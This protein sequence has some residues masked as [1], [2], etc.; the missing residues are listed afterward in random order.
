MVSVLFLPPVMSIILFVAVMYCLTNRAQL[1]VKTRER[2]EKYLKET[3]PYALQEYLQLEEDERFLV[4]HFL[5]T[6]RQRWN[7][8]GIYLTVRD[9]QGLLCELRSWSTDFQRMLFVMIVSDLALTLLPLAEQNETSL[10]GLSQQLIIN[11]AFLLWAISF[12]CIFYL[13]LKFVRL[14]SASNV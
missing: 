12:I 8:K 4:I 3:C 9:I 6:V 13:I 10:V 11:A 14:S 5:Y 1:E 7:T 2:E